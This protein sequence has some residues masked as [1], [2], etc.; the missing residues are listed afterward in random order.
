V[1]QGRST[2]KEAVQ[3]QIYSEDG[4]HV[5]LMPEPSFL[6]DIVFKKKKKS[7]YKESEECH[8]EGLDSNSSHQI[9]AQHRQESGRPFST[10]NELVVPNS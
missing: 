4:T 6:R 1:S 2:K 7:D 8:Q 5:P 3:A 10:P 9:T